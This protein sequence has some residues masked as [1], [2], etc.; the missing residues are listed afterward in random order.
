MELLL[1][2]VFAIGLP[3]TGLLFHHRF[4]RAIRQEEV[5]DSLERNRRFKQRLL[6]KQA[7]TLAR[8]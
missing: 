5:M 8:A 3:V 4:Q 2:L 6:Q 1:T 7:G